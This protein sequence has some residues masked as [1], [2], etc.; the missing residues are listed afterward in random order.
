M[1]VGETIRTILKSKNMRI[2][3]LAKMLGQDRRVI[4][5]TVRRESLTTKSLIKICKALGYKVVLMP[6]EKRLPDDSYEVE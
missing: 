4:D 5:S 6:I 1:N 2:A 3:T